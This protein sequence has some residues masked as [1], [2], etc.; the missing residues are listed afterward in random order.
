MPT[1]AHVGTSRQI[2]SAAAGTEAAAAARGGL[3]GRAPA[4]ALVFASA[5]HDHDQLIAAV[6]RQMAGVPVVGCSGEGVIAADDSNETLAA[7]AVMAVASDRMQFATFL[8]DDYGTD[9]S[10]AGRRLADAVNRC[11]DV[12]CLCV[13][14]DGLT[15]NCSDML[16]ALHQGLA[17]PVPVVGGAAA[18]AMSFDRTFQYGAGRAVSGGL[19]AFV[20]MGAA[21]VEVA[22]SHGCSPVGQEREVTRAD[23]GWIH[24][25]DGRPAWQLFKEYLADDADDL[26]AEG[27]VHLCLGERLAHEAD[28]YD[29]FVIR[30]PLQ[31]DKPT[32]ALFFPGGGLT[33]GRAIQLTRRDPDKIRASARACAAR[34]RDSHPGRAPDLVLQF[35]C[36]GRGRILWG[37]SAAAEIVAPLRQQLGPATP[38]M[39]FHTYG[40]I[41][42]IGGRPYYHNYTVALCAVYEREAA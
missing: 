41:A 32:G 22:V 16:K 11:R 25:I 38:W 6:E 35:D 17:R 36:A 8:V 9:S 28:H 19:A 20:I 15:G 18:D 21:D 26:N 24:E 7:T 31:L 30:T 12:R 1:F 13:M 33:E 42:P 4:L 34:L 27:I 39:G 23:G 29:P 37:G 2:D 10:G 5:D 40:E 14:P 3:H